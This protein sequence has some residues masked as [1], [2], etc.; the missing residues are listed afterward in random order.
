VAGEPILP[1]RVDFMKTERF[2]QKLGRHTRGVTLIRAFRAY[3]VSLFTVLLFAYAMML[4]AY[5]FPRLIFFPI[6]YSVLI[7]VIAGVPM[8][9]SA[10]VFWIERRDLTRVILAVERHYPHLSDRLITA[11]EYSKPGHPAAG[12]PISRLLVKSL[13]EEVSRIVEHCGFLRASSP[14]KLILPLFLLILLAVGG[15]VHAM[16]HP[17]F[18]YV[19]Y[20]RMA[21]LQTAVIAEHTVPDGPEKFL[22]EVIPGDCEIANGG[23]VLIQARSP[24]YHPQKMDLYLKS[25][26]RPG[27]QIFPM[28]KI[29]DDQYQILMTHLTS[30]GTYYIRA[31]HVESPRFEIRLFETLK[32]EKASW[33]IEFPAYMQL[34]EQL[35]QGWRDKL[36]VP[37]GTRLFLELVFNRP[38]QS[39][40]LTVEGKNA[41]ELK[42]LSENALAAVLTVDRD[43]IVR[44]AVQ[45][46]Q[47]DPIMGVAPLWVQAIPDL[48]PY[49]EVLEPQLQNYVFPSQEIPFEISANDDYG[50]NRVTL[51]VRYQGKETRIELLEPDARVDEVVLNY[52]LELE[53]FRL[54]SRDLI[55]AYVEVQDNYPEEEHIIRSPLF[56]FLT[57]DYVEQFKMNQ[58]ES[59][60]PSLRM[61]FENILTEQED[62]MRDT[63]DYISRMP[64]ENPAGWDP[65]ETFES[66]NQRANRGGYGRV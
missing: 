38:V 15:T 49:L 34:P 18:I 17:D 30:P 23:N 10:V 37:R 16:I 61:L 14:K 54:R 19:A 39:G 5:Y 12:N 6:H 1:A 44:M 2:D 3:A 46:M 47:N 35:R 9:V 62:I 24:G 33:R 26:S 41:F 48:S 59:K 60:E 27:W 63:W 40:W 53:R 25:L 7:G 31:D 8:M 65:A 28:K 21:G 55:F 64:V 42:A 20:Q 32:I 51:V 4:F 29:Q 36:T 57:R 50:L 45:G 22:I 66:E 52:T 13:Q 11:I 43:M 58:P 56:T